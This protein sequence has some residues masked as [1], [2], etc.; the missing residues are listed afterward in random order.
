MVLNSTLPILRV[1]SALFKVDVAKDNPFDAPDIGFPTPPGKFL[2]TADGYWLILKPLSPGPHDIHVQ[3]FV[4]VGSGL[5][6]FVI[7][8]A[9]HITVK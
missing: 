8:V 3:G 1:Q 5:P 2:A 6:D 9:Y 7:D 4:P